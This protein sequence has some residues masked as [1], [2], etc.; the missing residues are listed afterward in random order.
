MSKKIPAFTFLGD[1]SV[2]SSPE[3]W[4]FVCNIDFG[5]MRELGWYEANPAS[6]TV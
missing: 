6:N 3:V 4:L 5:A 1:Y 2:K